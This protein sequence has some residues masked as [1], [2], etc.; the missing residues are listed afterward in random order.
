MPF[1]DKPEWRLWSFFSSLNPQDF[2]VSGSQTSGLLQLS[3]VQ[4]RLSGPGSTLHSTVNRLNF[5]ASSIR[6]WL[7]CFQGLADACPGNPWQNILT[8]KVLHYPLGE[9]FPG[10]RSSAAHETHSREH[11]LY[12][13]HLYILYSSPPDAAGTRLSAAAASFGPVV[14]VALQ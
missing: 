4:K 5:G 8:P 3:K 12:R 2:K 13:T 11:I 1:A 14:L 10:I 7:I 6:V 9:N